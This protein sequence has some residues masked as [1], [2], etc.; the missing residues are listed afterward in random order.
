MKK[1]LSLV[2]MLTMVL[3]GFGVFA[4]TPSW[5]YPLHDA[6]LSNCA[7][8]M[9]VPT[10][11]MR[12]WSFYPVGKQIF[13]PIAIDE[14]VYFSDDAGN[15]YC[16]QRKTGEEVWRYNLGFDEASAVIA[17][18]G[19][20]IIF[21]GSNQGFMFGG[22]R[23]RPSGGGDTPPEQLEVINFIGALDLATGKEIW[24]KEFKEGS[25]SFPSVTKDRIIIPVSDMLENRTII[26][27]L[28][29]YSTEDCSELWTVNYSQTYAS[30]PTLGDGKVFMSGEK[31]VFEEGQDFPSMT[32]LEI[33]AYNEKDGSLVWT[34]K[35]N[36][37]NVLGFPSYA[38]GKIYYTEALMDFGRAGGRG[39]F[40]PPDGWVCSINSSDGSE[41][42]RTKIEGE[43][44]FY[45]AFPAITPHGIVVQATITN[46]MCFDKDTGVKKWMTKTPG[47]FSFIGMQFACTS[48]QMV[49]VRQ[50]KISVLDLTTGEVKFSEDTGIK[51]GNMMRGEISFSFPIVSGDMV[52]IGADRLLA[53]GE[54]I[55]KLMSEPDQIAVERI[56]VGEKKTRKLRVVFNGEGVIEGTLKATQPWI[57][58]S[59]E[60][61]K[62]SSQYYEV[63]LSAEVLQPG[64]YEGSIEVDSTVGKLSIP[65]S[66]NVIT[67]PPIKL[68]VN[69]DDQAFTNQNPFKVTG[70]TVPGAT[71]T[72]T[73][74]PINVSSDG[75]FADEIPLKSGSNRLIFEAKDNKGNGATVIKVVILDDRKPQIQISLKEGEIVS[76]LPL[77]ITG[78]TERGSKLKINGEP[79]E[80]QDNGEFTIDFPDLKD[81]LYTYTFEATDRSGNITKR[82]VH[83]AV[84]TVKI[85]IELEIKE[86]SITNKPSFDVKGKT[87]PGAM[88]MVVS[89]QN[90]AGQAV[91]DENGSF[92]IP[93]KLQEGP[94][95][96][97]VIA[98][99][100]SGKRDMKQFTVVL[101]TKPPE[102][103]IEIPP[104]VS[105]ASLIIIGK[106]EP[107]TLLTINSKKI[108]V[109]EDGSFE[110]TLEL[111]PGLNSITIIAYDEATNKTVI[112]TYTK[113]ETFK[114][115]AIKLWLGKL[116]YEVNGE[117]LQL[118]VAPTSF[119]PPL[120]A[121]LAG[122]TYMTITEVAKALDVKVEWDGK[123]KKVTLT[124]TL[125][126]GKKKLIEL[127]IGK[128]QAKI[129]NK[130]VWID[131]KHKLYPTTV[132][133][134]T[135]LPLR[136]VGEAL[137]CKVEFESQAK[138]ITLT[139][140]Q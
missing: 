81:G 102:V 116:D 33:L 106:T 108:D 103:K 49:N 100:E 66:M 110:I 38:E 32:N 117:K 55:I 109:K 88:V 9:N 16:I 125:F 133:G 128:N 87:M 104:T 67:K 114:R 26:S 138:M 14:L 6:G 13:F 60:V 82:E 95:Q 90:P 4:Q 48:N 85:T 89:G 15:I 75:K 19:D 72:V 35:V 20:K 31:I 50:S 40:Q 71:V 47:G 42:F 27:K 45:F 122:S 44:F 132:G 91:A 83:F 65:V 80:V 2:V 129:D 25:Y 86:Q 1:L 77:T 139:Y 111:K 30:A 137:G 78:Q 7:L 140:P 99:T 34:K 115:I 120:P 134:K 41:R 46:S 21:V 8:D 84:D 123:E 76:Q 113:F 92:K 101:D 124:Q 54:K 28:K 52:F 18:T 57:R 98:S 130:E 112:E 36:E 63:E 105:V 107:K 24:K 12:L 118:K 97:M 61:Y 136:F 62:Y 64:K 74:R 135:M 68:I 70:E 5:P 69:L 59:S 53:Y 10:P 121:E 23:G 29:A 79:I 126:G 93:I 11:L 43:D 58:L 56:I 17:S 127:W 131:S 3:T 22:M 94:N 39:N 119:A 37:G 96:F 51:S 73:G